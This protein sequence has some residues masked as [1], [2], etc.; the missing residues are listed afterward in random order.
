M[1]LG[2]VDSIEVRVV[3]LHDP[4]DI[5]VEVRTSFFGQARLS[6]LGRENDV[7]EDLGER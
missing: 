7:L 4:P 5:P 6:I 2:P 1:V 3:V